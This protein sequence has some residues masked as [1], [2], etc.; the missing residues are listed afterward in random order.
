MDSVCG[1]ADPTYMLP[2]G[3]D[4]L[5]SLPWIQPELGVVRDSS[6]RKLRGWLALSSTPRHLAAHD[7]SHQT[8]LVVLPVKRGRPPQLGETSS[9][10]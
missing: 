2:V 8:G 5:K 9:N 10:P 3:T 6:T 4:H 7:L 1:P